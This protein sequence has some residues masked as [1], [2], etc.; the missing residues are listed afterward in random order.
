MDTSPNYLV[1]PWITTKISVYKWY[2][3]STTQN[4]VI[5]FI[6]SRA[7]PSDIS[8]K[9]NSMRTT[10]VVKNFSIVYNLQISLCEEGGEVVDSTQC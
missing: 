1:M 6:L 2:H 7:H 4:W 3:I 10:T 9:F 8:D 5:L